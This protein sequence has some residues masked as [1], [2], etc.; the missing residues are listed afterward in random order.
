MDPAIAALVD[1]RPEMLVKEPHLRQVGTT[2]LHRWPRF[3][4]KTIAAERTDEQAISSQQMNDARVSV[5]GPDLTR[6]ARVWTHGVAK[7][8]RG[9]DEFA[10]HLR[11]LWGLVAGVQARPAAVVGP[12]QVAISVATH[13]A[14]GD[15]GPT[16]GARERFR[17]ARGPAVGDV[18]DHRR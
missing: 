4:L 5:D 18:G 11:T 7:Q 15:D 3:A 14:A 17:A 12:H 8:P 9:A 1:G 16:V 10:R 13:R 6:I 2:R